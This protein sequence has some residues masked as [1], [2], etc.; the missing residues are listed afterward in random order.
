MDEWISRAHKQL[1][2]H[3]RKGMRFMKNEL[4]GMF[5]REHHSS[6][7]DYLGHLEATGTEALRKRQMWNGPR[8][9]SDFGII[10][11]V[12]LTS[13]FLV[14][15]EPI[16]QPNLVYVFHLVHGVTEKM[17]RHGCKL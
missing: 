11:K 16:L 4:E 2:L 15:G 7:D 17:V 10:A 9:E 1:Q 5:S 14:S 13:T 8:R 6:L 12:T 3:D